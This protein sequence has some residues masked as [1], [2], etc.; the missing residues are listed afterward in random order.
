MNKTEAALVIKG[1]EPCSVSTN[2]EIGLPEQIPNSLE[3]LKTFSKF[4]NYYTADVS[5]AQITFSH[6]PCNAGVV[7]NDRCGLD[8]EYQCSTKSSAGT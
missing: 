7:P 3:V 6:E 8:T 4:H 2:P 1:E 5:T